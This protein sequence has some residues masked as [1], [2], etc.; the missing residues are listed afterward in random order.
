[1]I[2]NTKPFDLF[3]IGGGINGCGIARDAAGRGH[4]VYLCEQDDLAS[5]TS[6]ASSKMIHGGLRYLEYYEFRLVRE[7]LAERD[8]LLNIAPHLIEPLRL[9]IPHNKLQRP[10]WMV[11]IGIWLYDHLGFHFGKKSRLPKSKAISLID[12]VEGKPIKDSMARAFA[13]SDCKVDDARL[14]VA[15]AKSAQ[16]LG[17]SI[18]TRT[19]FVTAKR[20]NG[21]WHCTV[22]NSTGEYTITAKAIVNAAGPWV[23]KVVKNQLPITTQHHIRL[24]KGSHIVV[25]K[26]YDGN[27]AYLLQNKDNRVVFVIPYHDDFTM[28]GTTDILFEG[29]PSSVDISQ[30][31]IDYLCEAVNDYF[32][33]A[34]SADDIVNTWSGVRPL[35]ADEADNPSAVTRD[36]VL[37]VEED[38]NHQLPVLSIFGGKITTYRKLAEHAMQKLE[39]YFPEQ[40]KAWTDQDALPGG[41]MLN[42]NFEQFLAELQ[43]Q[44]VWLPESLSARL[45]HAYGTDAYTLLGDASNMGDLGRNFGA[46][47]YNIEVDHL[48]KHEWAHTTDDILW[49]RTKLGLWFTDEQVAELAAYLK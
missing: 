44:Y 21:L 8:V 43:S 48:I 37:E 33:Q 20:E 49:R 6:S 28:I 32:K 2:D 24:I 1:M 47:L 12:S 40:A 10:H 41:D 14:V 27:H 9:I 4:S 19:Q 30:D 17:A 16:Q 39:R 7:A 25:P 45:A 31:E 15:N 11:R 34:I 29:N 23:D 38:D 3:I 13:Y 35:Q 36:Y 22:K 5:H 42:A 46:N 26:C 18:N